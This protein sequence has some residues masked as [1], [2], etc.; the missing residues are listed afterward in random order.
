[1]EAVT[2]SPKF[3][4]VIPRAV[5]ERMHIQPGEKLQ[6]ICFDDRIEMV[7]TR[8]MGEMRGFLKGLDPAFKLVKVDFFAK[9]IEKPQEL[10]I[11]TIC[12]YEVFKKVN[13]V[14]DE[15]KA[16]Q[17]VA[18]M[19]QGKVSDLTEDIAISASLISIKHK[20]PMADS[21]IYATAKA[22]DAVTWTQDQDFENMPGVK[23]S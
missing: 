4:V 16:L 7:R 8:P 2:V 6:V 1:M 17:A 13:I 23:S 3:Q 21:M 10:L 5:R 14:A 20:L 22:H 9:P 12:I 18:Q 15:A 11:P 19:R